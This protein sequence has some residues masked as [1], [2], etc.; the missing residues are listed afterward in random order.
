ML[1]VVV[2]NRPALAQHRRFLD[3]D[4]NRR[5]HDVQVEDVRALDPRDRTREDREQL[6]LVALFE[7][8]LDTSPHG[9]AMLDLHTTSGTAPPF[10]V[11]VDVDDNRDLA[12]QLGHPIITGFAHYVDG[13]I[14]V[15]WHERGLPA[16]GVEGGRHDSV[17]AIDHLADTAWAAMAALGMVDRAGWS[18]AEVCTDDPPVLRIVYRHG[19]VPGAGFRMEPGFQSFQPVQRGQLLASDA[20]GPIRALDDGQVFLP[21]YQ[22]QGSDGFF[23]IARDD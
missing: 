1:L 14:L 23:L 9:V 17:D 16:V 12:R 11:I 20:T 3:R 8:V 6:D 21:L 7:H 5:W 13:P 19:V 18:G 22:D 15:W 2:G 10:S 4:L